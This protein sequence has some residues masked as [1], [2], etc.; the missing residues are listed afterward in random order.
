MDPSFKAPG[1]EDHMQRSMQKTRNF[2]PQIAPSGIV[3][4]A[5]ERDRRGPE[6]KEVLAEESRPGECGHQSNIGPDCACDV[7]A[8]P[9]PGLKDDKQRIVSNKQDVGN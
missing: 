2:R 3:Q 6:N 1:Y 9:G 4:G 5:L 8:N 7:W